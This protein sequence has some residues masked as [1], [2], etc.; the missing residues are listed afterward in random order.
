MVLREA[1]SRNSAA[2]K[3]MRACTMLVLYALGVCEAS[4]SLPLGSYV[5]ANSTDASILPYGMQLQEMNVTSSGTSTV[6]KKRWLFG[7]DSL[8]ESYVVEADGSTS[9]NKI[10]SRIFYFNVFMGVEYNTSGEALITLS[11]TTANSFHV[12][13]PLLTSQASMESVETHSLHL[14]DNGCLSYRVESSVPQQVFTFWMKTN[15]SNVDMCGEAMR[16][17]TGRLAHGAEVRNAVAIN[18]RRLSADG[19]A[20][21]TSSDSP[22]VYNYNVTDSWFQS[23]LGLQV[24]VM[25]IGLQGLANGRSGEPLLYLTYPADWAYSYTPLV[26]EYVLETYNMSM[27]QLPFIDPNASSPE[28]QKALEFLMPG[29]PVR[30][31]A[32]LSGVILWDTESRPSLLV[33]M[34]AAG[35][36]DALVLTPALYYMFPKELQ[37]TLPVL[38]DFSTRFRLRSEVQV[39]KWAYDTYFH[40]CNHTYLLWLGGECGGGEVRPGV[41]DFG[42]SK[43]SFFVDLN[44]TPNAS[45]PE[46]ILAN[47]IVSATSNASGG[48]F[49]LQGWHSY[50]KDQ[51]HTFTTLASKHGGRVHGLNTNPNLSFMNNIK[52]P[53]NFT[54]K[55]NHA[56]PAEI[57][58]SKVYITF[59]QTDGIGLG[60]WTLPGRGSLPYSWEVTIPDLWIQPAILRMFYD[61]ATE[62]DTFVGALS[63]P[64]YM[65]PKAQPKSLL[66]PLLKD[67]Q[68]YLTRL[69]LHHMIIFDASATVG[70]HT[71]TGDCNL[72]EDIMDS[73]FDN[74]PDT[75]GFMNGYAPAFSAKYRNSTAV[76]RD[77]RGLRFAL[78]ALGCGRQRRCAR[79]HFCMKIPFLHLFRVGWP[80]TQEF[81]IV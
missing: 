73:Y 30:D 31:A 27:Q 57:D 29:H 54:F 9:H 47:E 10:E 8:E 72:P 75:V 69:D 62:N 5:W 44:T 76:C 45:D 18:R 80:T 60:A 56:A 34:T 36:H 81:G 51:E 19:Q 32:R 78:R 37:S 23:D 58:L 17:S 55:N 48:E 22:I 1:F 77:L 61:Q 7:S 52:L 24:N 41:A 2:Y 74:M 15:T 68:S 16:E 38:E 25:M 70:E 66:G 49:L 50:C 67:T 35:I 71:A 40:E 53:A 13:R 43:R 46:Y 3:T 59:V 63:G 28:F 20:A 12:Q 21:T 64:G 4:S 6:I 42:T 14:N 39:Y 79:F 65:Y 33:A 11:N 26:L